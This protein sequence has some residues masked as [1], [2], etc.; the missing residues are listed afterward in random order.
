[1]Q[2]VQVNEKPLV[3]FRTNPNT[4]LDA[5]LRYVVDPKEAG[6]VKSELTRKLLIA[7]RNEPDRVLFP[8]SN[9]R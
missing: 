7:L 3:I 9:L 2:D 8:K 6:Q 5:I 1:V 4:W